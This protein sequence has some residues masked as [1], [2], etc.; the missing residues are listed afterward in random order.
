MSTQTVTIKNTQNP[1][2][3]KFE[4]SDFLIQGSFEFKNIDE[5]KNAPLAQKLFY[6]PF[7]K[8]VYM[9]GNFIAVE[10]FS[11]VEWPDVQEDV[12]EEISAFLNG[13][14]QLILETQPTSKA[15]PISVY[16]ETTPNP[17]TLK[18]VVNR[19]ITPVTAH[20]SNIDEA[21]PSVLAQELFKFHYVKEVFLAEN[22]VSIS[23]YETTSW[24]EITL[25][26][27]SFIKQFIEN[28][29]QVIDPTGITSKAVETTETNANNEPL[30]ATS[31]QIIAILDEYIK[32]AVTADGGNIQFDSFDPVEKRVKVILQGSCNGCPSS[33]FTLKNGIE[34][35]LKDMLHEPNLV[36]EALNG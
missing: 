13:G 4:L 24:D 28:G 22:Y 2:I 14:G 9:S 36:V 25:E 27:R 16:G 6:L 15:L 20:F 30:D 32:P 5:T 8:T 1:N 26:L 3:V 12:A 18:F 11:I 29:G 17:S 23:K 34:N 21:A 33:T 7:V 19:L 10:R 35:I 31:E